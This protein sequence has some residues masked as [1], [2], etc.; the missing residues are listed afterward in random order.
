MPATFVLVNYTKKQI[1]QYLNL[2]CGTQYEITN[3]QIASTITTWYLFQNSG[4]NIVFVNCTHDWHEELNDYPD[5]T[6]AIIDELIK[7]GILVECE[8]S[9]LY[10]YPDDDEDDIDVWLRNVKHK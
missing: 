8:P 9:R 6:H 4:D 5:Q 10:I 3:N 1:I 2:P 7:V